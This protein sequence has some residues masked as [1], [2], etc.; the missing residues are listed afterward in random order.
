MNPC[1][2][3]GREALPMIANFG[4]D[5]GAFGIVY[6]LGDGGAREE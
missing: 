4:E 6:D 5:L 1:P 2:D 3:I